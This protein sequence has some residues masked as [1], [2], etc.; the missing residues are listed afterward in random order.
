MSS[1]GG[2]AWAWEAAEQRVMPAGVRRRRRQVA[3]LRLCRASPW[4]S[5]GTVYVGRLRLLASRLC[6]D[7]KSGPKTSPPNGLVKPEGLLSNV[8]YLVAAHGLGRRQ[9]SR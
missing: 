3:P 5:T 4:S 7:P 1:I 8:E 9:S 2:G 6:Y